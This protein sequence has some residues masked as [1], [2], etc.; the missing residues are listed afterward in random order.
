MSRYIKQEWVNEETPLNSDHMSH[1]EEGIFDTNLSLGV[2][3]V[4]EGNN[5]TLTLKDLS[6]LVDG[7]IKGQLFLV[8]QVNDESEKPLLI[9]FDSYSTYYHGY[10]IG[11]GGN[12]LQEFRVSASAFDTTKIINI[13]SSKTIVNGIVVSVSPSTTLY[14]LPSGLFEIAHE[15]FSNRLFVGKLKTIAYDS[16]THVSTYEAYVVELY[17]GNRWF[18]TGFTESMTLSSFL[19]DANRN[20][21]IDTK[22]SQTNITGTKQ[23]NG[24]VGFSISSNVDFSSIPAFSAGFKNTSTGH[25]YTENIYG[26]IVNQGT[27]DVTSTYGITIPNTTSWTSDRVISTT[28]DQSLTTTTGSESVIINGDILNVVTRDTDQTITGQKTFTSTPFFDWISVNTIG[29]TQ[30]YI[31][32]YLNAGTYYRLDTSTFRPTTTNLR[33]LGTSSYSWKDVYVSGSLKD[34]N[35]SSVTIANIVDK[36]NPQ[37]ISGE[38]TFENDL[39]IKS[40]TYNSSSTSYKLVAKK[41]EYFDW[42]EIDADSGS[43]YSNNAQVYIGNLRVGGNLG[44]TNLLNANEGDV[45]FMSNGA[46]NIVPD[47][48]NQ[49][50][51][52]RSNKRWKDI[53][54]GGNLSDGTN[55]ITVSQ[56]VNNKADKVGPLSYYTASMNDNILDFIN[57]NSV[58]GKPIIISVSDNL[59]IGEFYLITSYVYTFEFEFMYNGSRYYGEWV[60]LTNKKFSDIFSS[61]YQKNL[62]IDNDVVH[63]SG[64]ETISGA[65]TFKS[66]KLSIEEVGGISTA[67]FTFP[68]EGRLTVDKDFSVPL[69]DTNSIYAQGGR[70]SGKYN[71]NESNYGILFPN[72]DAWTS[73][74]TIAMIDD[75]SSYHD[76]TKLDKVTSPAY[77]RLYAITSMGEQKVVQYGDGTDNNSVVQRTSTGQINVPTTPTNN[78][79]ATSKKYVDDADALKV[80][81][82]T[83]IIG[84]T[85]CK[86]TYDSKGL[87]T[88]GADLEASDIPSLDAGKITSGTLSTSRIPNL[89]ASKITSGTLDSARIPDI[90][91]TKADAQTITGKKTFQHADGIVIS[92]DG[93]TSASIVESTGGELDDDSMLSINADYTTLTGV[94]TSTGLLNANTFEF[95]KWSSDGNWQPVIYA[96]M[97]FKVATSSS[98]STPTKGVKF[99]DTSSWSADKTLATTDQATKLYKHMI[100]STDSSDT[101][102]LTVIS[103]TN[104]QFT[105]LSSSVQ[106]TVFQENLVSMLFATGTTLRDS[107]NL[108]VT[109]YNAGTFTAIDFT[110]TMPTPIPGVFTT[111]Y[112]DVQPL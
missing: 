38:K 85:K 75:I 109:H 112:D 42:L 34:N 17:S 108:L 12:S 80:T 5:S 45:T 7:D 35:N 41:D 103:T 59:V 20:D 71:S 72:T 64:T 92:A 82:N 68:S 21:F 11:L 89:S 37:T 10:L 93:T 27:G 8:K 76:S 94:V 48:D 36:N 101:G 18:K 74:K 4:V 43:G 86:I 19:V 52:G 81:A 60:D 54:L 77:P 51:L 28:S 15:N 9:S 29:S 66:G 61:T 6:D 23:F 97:T 84:A 3:K 65:K 32:F 16:S 46:Q 30:S 104:T 102:I 24:Y 14:E 58:K 79:H 111:V 106:D 63:K 98:S 91:V 2:I 31:N 33:D 53:Y 40:P 39:I 25:S 1:I 83:A 110:K 69:L 73:D 55:S 22:S 99:P 57:N 78:G 67:T 96:G 50:G 13:S 49:A 105:D 95:D 90:Y 47:I 56:L 87:V 100:T 70:F 44:V 26:R 88:T 107:K 62:A